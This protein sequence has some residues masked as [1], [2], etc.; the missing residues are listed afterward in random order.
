MPTLLTANDIQLL[1]SNIGVRHRVS[2]P[3]IESMVRRNGDEEDESA[4]ITAHEV[5]DLIA[6]IR[7]M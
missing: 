4:P 3:T 6:Q 5:I 2:L 1:L 7:S